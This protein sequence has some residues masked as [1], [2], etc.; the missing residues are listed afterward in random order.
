[1]QPPEFG[2][3]FH[4]NTIIMRKKPYAQPDPRLLLL[5]IILLLFF[6]A[7]ILVMSIHN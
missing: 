5:I 6:V 7:L 3:G 1:M 4:I 2:F